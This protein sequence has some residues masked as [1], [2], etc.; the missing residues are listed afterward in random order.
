M[1]LRRLP[2]CSGCKQPATAIYNGRLGCNR[3]DLIGPSIK[4]AVVPSNTETSQ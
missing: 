4:P 3:C 2:D 1:T